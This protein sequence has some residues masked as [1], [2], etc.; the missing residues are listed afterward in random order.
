VGG[1]LIHGSKRLREN[2]GS[3]AAYLAPNRGA[4]LV[5]RTHKAKIN[6]TKNTQTINY[7]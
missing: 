4:R 3:F 2:D 6:L 1:L 7:I 5:L